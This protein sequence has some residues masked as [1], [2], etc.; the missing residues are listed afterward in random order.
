MALQLQLSMYN[1]KYLQL[2]IKTG[3]LAEG[4][5][6]PDFRCPKAY[7][8]ICSALLS[9]PTSTI[10]FKGK[11]MMVGLFFFLLFFSINPHTI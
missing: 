9:Q 3:E 8:D 10:L 1:T 4:L 5:F 11:D 7:S 2:P 6:S